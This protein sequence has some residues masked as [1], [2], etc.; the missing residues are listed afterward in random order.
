[1]LLPGDTLEVTVEAIRED[2]GADV[3]ASQNCISCVD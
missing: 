2:G 1:M 3:T